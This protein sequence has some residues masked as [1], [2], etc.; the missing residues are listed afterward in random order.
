M[1][2]DSTTQPHQDIIIR[3]PELV[4]ST[5]SQEQIALLQNPRYLDLVRVLHEKGA[6]TIEEIAEEYA[7]LARSDQAKSESTVYR[8]LTLLK[9]HDIV[10]EAGQRVIPGK[11]HSRTLYSLTAKYLIVNEPEIDWKGNYGKRLFKDVVSIL[12]T[13][14]TE[15]LIDEKALFQW[16]LRFQRIVSADRQKLIDSKDPEILKLLSVWAPYTVMDLMEYL[17]WNSALLAD[18]TIQEDFLNCFGEVTELEIPSLPTKD[19]NRK[20]KSGT[21]YMDLIRQRSK[22]YFN[23]LDS[24]P[25][26]R[27]FDKP[28]YL[29]LFHVLRDQPMTIEELAEKYNQVAT[30][31]RKIS[32]IYRYV[33][34]LKEATLLI[35]MGQRVVDGKKTTQRL[36]GP[37]ARLISLQGKYESEWESE[38]RLWLLNSVI[39]MLHYLYPELPKIDRDKFREFRA[40]ASHFEMEGNQRFT[41]PENRHII[42]LFHKYDWKGFYHMY[43]TFWNYYYFVSMANLRERLQECFSDS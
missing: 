12:R 38:I 1:A 4:M 21:L 11:I 28:A 20:I 23:L 5:L 29:P 25:R 36:Y 31:P 37:I 35:E 16:Q 40:S 17:G 24:D 30:V 8:Y 6:M 22:L 13:L 19:E 34:T 32:T 33:K 42:E 26:Q 10:Q 27:Y 2:Q 7:A 9:R 3:E 15:K 43:T 41:L 39:R 18:P 14:Y